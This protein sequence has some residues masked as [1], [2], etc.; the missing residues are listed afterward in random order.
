M[1]ANSWADIRPTGNK[2][3]CIFRVI[4]RVGEISSKIKRRENGLRDSYFVYFLKRIQA[5]IDCRMVII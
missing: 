1:I 3:G 5:T 4:S 2:P